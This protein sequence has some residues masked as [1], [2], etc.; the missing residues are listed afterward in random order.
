MFLSVSSVA[1]LF[2]DSFYLKDH[3]VFWVW[4]HVV[5]DVF[6]FCP[7]EFCAVSHGVD[8]WKNGH[9]SA[10]AY[11]AFDCTSVESDFVADFAAEIALSLHA[12]DCDFNIIRHLWFTVIGSI[13]FRHFISLVS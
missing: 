11:G 13:A 9:Q 8:F 10:V 4:T 1:V 5:D 12:F 3:W 7:W 6:V 2:S